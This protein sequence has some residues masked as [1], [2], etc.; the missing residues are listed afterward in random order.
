MICWYWSGCIVS[1]ISVSFAD[2]GLERVRRS[3][4]TSDIFALGVPG[5]NKSSYSTNCEFSIDME[6]VNILFPTMWFPVLFTV[7]SAMGGL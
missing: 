5:V 4:D 7:Y 1:T 6:R 3:R 2:F